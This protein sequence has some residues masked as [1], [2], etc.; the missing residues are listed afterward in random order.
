[1]TRKPLRSL[2]DG[3]DGPEVALGHPDPV[4]GAHADCELVADPLADPLPLVLAPQQAVAVQH[5]GLGGSSRVRG[6]TQVKGTSSV[7]LR[8]GDAAGSVPLLSTVPAS[9]APVR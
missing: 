6:I 5:G 8:R 1:M 4:D 7:P 3:D 2:E 9:P